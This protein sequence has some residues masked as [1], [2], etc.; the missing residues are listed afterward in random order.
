MYGVAQQ[1]AVSSALD[2]RQGP[3]IGQLLDPVAVGQAE[4]EDRDALEPTEFLLD[5]PDG[6]ADLGIVG[7]P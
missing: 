2:Q 5:R 1:R 6:D 7:P 3:R 4:D